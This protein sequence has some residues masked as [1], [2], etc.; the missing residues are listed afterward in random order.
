MHTCL[1]VDEILRLLAWELVVSEE[2]SAAVALA[3]CCKGFEEPVLDTLW[4]TQDRLTPLLKCFPQDIWKEEEERFV[5]P[6]TTFILSPLNCSIRKSFERIPTKAEWAHSLK[7]ARRMRKLKVDTSADPV[8]SDI[9]QAL[10]PH[11]VN[12]PWLPGLKTFK[13]NEATEAFIPLIPSFLS[14]QTTRIKIRFADGSPAVV[15]ASIISK[16]SM[17]CPNL[18]RIT[19]R[20]PPRD[21]VIVDAV[22]EMVLGCNREVLR[23][24]EVDSPL[25]EEAREVVYQL[26]KLF[27]LWANI[28]GPT[29]LPTMTLPNLFA[30][31]LR[32]EHDLDWLEGFRGATLGSLKL[33]TFHSESEHIGDFLQA[34]ESVVLT[35]SAQNTL[36]MFRFCTMRSWDPNYSS[37]LSFCQ[38]Q[39]LRIEFTCDDGCSSKVDDD[40]IISLA[41]AMPKLEFLQLGASPCQTPTGITVNGLIGLACRCPNLTHLCVHFQGTSLAE[42]ATSATTPPPLDDE[43]IVWREEI[44]VLTSLKV[45]GIPIPAGSESAI[46]LILLQIFPCIVNIWY[47]NEEWETV[48]KTILDFRRIGAFVHRS[49][50]AHPSHLMILSDTLPGDAIGVERPSGGGQA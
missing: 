37:L 11:I 39:H 7:Y 41:G 45:G 15:V 43:F 49:S 21:S 46:T 42:A 19:L 29:S 28:Q 40:I 1:Y 38:L 9:I 5:S 34:F 10:Q 35:T 20:V 33:A 2:K 48:A 44:C 6:L 22:S 24:F 30:I 47:I 26:P 16:F 4:E 32:Y 13:C 8:S 27:S 3:C 36:F 50:K 14:P 31:D 23:E 17:L 25:T 18:E 12:G